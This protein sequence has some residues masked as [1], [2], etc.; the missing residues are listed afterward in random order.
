MRE[1]GRA[2]TKEGRDEGRGPSEDGRGAGRGKGAERRR[3]RSG[4]R[5]EVG[6]A[7][8]P[9]ASLRENAPRCDRLARGLKD[10]KAHGEEG[11]SEYAND[12]AEEADKRV[13]RYEHDGFL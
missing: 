13:H 6:C 8:V 7:C 2:K 9:S 5:E 11:G 10:W 4:T 1:E 3:K 12:L